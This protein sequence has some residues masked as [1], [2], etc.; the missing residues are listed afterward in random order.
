MELQRL[1]KICLLQ[2]SLYA[3][4][5]RAK[6]VYDPELGEYRD[7]TDLLMGVAMV[8]MGVLL[9]YPLKGW[10]E[11]HPWLAAAAFFLVPVF[12]GVIGGGSCTQ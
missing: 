1:S 2:I 8:L 12:L 5:L 6:C 11:E 3:N 9:A 7:S 10:A 4:C